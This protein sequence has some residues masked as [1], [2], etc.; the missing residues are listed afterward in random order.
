MLNEKD[1][2][3]IEESL[4]AI[5]HISEYTEQITTLEELLKDT[6]TYDAVMMNFIVLG[7]SASKLSDDIKSQLPHVDWRAIKGFRN[8]LAHDYFGVDENIVWAAIRVHLPHLKNDFE[9]L[10]HNS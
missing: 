3:Y 2:I 1:S 9:N 7:E 10:L 4:Y 6:K 5:N 8:F